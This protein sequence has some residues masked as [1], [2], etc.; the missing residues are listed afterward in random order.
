MKVKGP[1]AANKKKWL[2]GKKVVLNRDAGAMAS[3]FWLK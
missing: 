1:A 2:K 3:N